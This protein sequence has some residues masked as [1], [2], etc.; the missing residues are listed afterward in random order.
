MADL[1]VFPSRHESYGLTL[2]EA[3][4]AGLPAVCLDSAG[5]RS[6]MRKEFGA[7]VTPGELRAA[8][9]RL[10]AD[11]TMRAKMGTAAREFA[12]NEKFSD[13]AA[14]LAEIILAVNARE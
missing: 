14:K 8:I 13:Q 3:L 6:V 2:L 12:K 5:A 4:A 1:Y 7:I 11:H 9:E 10:L